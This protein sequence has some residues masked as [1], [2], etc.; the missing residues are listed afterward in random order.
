MIERF[1]IVLIV[2]WLALGLGPAS[3]DVLELRGGER[4]EGVLKEATPAGVTI[5]IAGQSIKFDGSIV[6]A[7]YFGSPA[8]LPPPLPAPASLQPSSP[9]APP[10]A[11]GLL[12]LVK[13]LRPAAGAGTMLNEY[14]ARMTAAAPIVDLYLAALAPGSGVDAVRDAMRYYVLAESA[15]DNLGRASRTVWLKR[16]DALGRCP[17]YRDFVQAMQAKGEAYYAERT[18]N[19]VNVADG[20]IP[21]LWSCASEKIAEAETLLVEATK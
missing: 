12:Q 15:W 6:R 11:A 16:D 3:A 4:V 14:Q 8:S 1:A 10:S 5:E 18:R 17:A 9:K 13:S 19:Y 7:I 20:V 2:I 21:V